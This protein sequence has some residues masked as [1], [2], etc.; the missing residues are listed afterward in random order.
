MTFKRK[1]RQE[2]RSEITRAKIIDSAK[3][4][5]LE[6]GFN[7][8]TVNLIAKEAKI[9][10]GTVYS[11]FPSGKDEVL[12]HII[13]E[14][15]HYFYEIAETVYT[16]KNNEEAYNFTLKNTTDFLKLAVIHRDI[17]AVFYEAIG[18]SNLIRFKWESIID[19]FINRVAKNVVIVKEI[20]LIKN[21][22]YNPHIVAGSLIYP[23]EK[24]LWKIAQRKVK[25]D[26]EEI[27]KN[28]A[29]IYTYGLF[30]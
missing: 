15:M 10:Y 6:Q 8:A 27:A 4:I 14:I 11:H 24:F 29:G 23:G 3:I 2:L 12:L 30:K 7:H 9:G 22:N 25:I 1:N 17:L 18:M 13:E 16:P 20:G 19:E 26:Y 21:E 5:F 28:V